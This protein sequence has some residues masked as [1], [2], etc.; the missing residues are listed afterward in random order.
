MDE[1]LNIEW[2]DNK[3]LQ[4]KHVPYPDY[5]EN[6]HAKL[7]PLKEFS[8]LRKYKKSEMIILMKI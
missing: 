1:V 3:K 7:D 8:F 2:L 5:N 6:W 4:H